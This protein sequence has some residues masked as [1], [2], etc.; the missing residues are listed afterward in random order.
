[1]GIPSTVDVDIGWI[2]ARSPRGRPG[3]HAWR[4]VRVDYDRQAER[5]DVGRRVP[6]ET[7][8]PWRGVIEHILPETEKPIL[9]L[10]A[11]TGIWMGAFSVW[12]NIPV[13]A[14]EPSTGMRSVGT[15]AGLPERARYVS[16][17][18]ESLPLGLST[19]RAAWLS[20][21]VHHLTDMQVCAMELRRV[22]MEGAPVMIRNT[23]ALR[24]DEVQLFRYFPAAAAV[25]AAWPTVQQVVATFAGAG[26]ANSV[27]TRMHEDRWRDL[28]Q[29]RDFAVTMRHTDSA[30]VPIS[31][32]AFAE[33]LD[34]LD[35]AIA[36]GQHPQPEGVDLLVLS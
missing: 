21:V 22:L 9:D 15:A 35:R 2:R 12:F 30:L 7:L 19:C 33:G 6:I 34:G 3:C 4:V 36:E 14:V 11:G 31:D 25:A 20:T 23:F 17:R 28:Q 18:A 29:L 26:F 24:H 5:Y 10:G 16:A 13:V 32:A 27:L 1:M 8:E